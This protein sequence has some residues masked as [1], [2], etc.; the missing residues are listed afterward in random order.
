MSLDIL[1]RKLYLIT[2]YLDELQSISNYS[3]EEY[4]QNYFIKYSTE[5]ILQLII[6][7]IISVNNKLL[8]FRSVKP[9]EDYSNSLIKMDELGIFPIEFCEQLLPLGV[10]YD[11]LVNIHEYEDI[12]DR[13]VYN[14][15]SVALK[16]YKQ[17]LQ[18]IEEYLD[19][20]LDSSK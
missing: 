10:L 3:F 16:Y 2:T 11:Q 14:S 15:I 13:V 4:T 1:Q 12:N 8:I 18:Y 7:T 20:M 19:K 5:R 17:Y 9:G 6:D